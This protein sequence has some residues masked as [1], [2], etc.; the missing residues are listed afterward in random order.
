M[1]LKAMKEIAQWYEKKEGV[2]LQSNVNPCIFA[3]LLSIFNHD[4]TH[5]PTLEQ[6]TQEPSR[7]P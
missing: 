3:A 5:I 7:F 6:K 2:F 1:D 4:Q